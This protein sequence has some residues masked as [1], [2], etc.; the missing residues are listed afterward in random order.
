[1]K[2]KLLNL[3]RAR[4]VVLDLPPVLIGCYRFSAKR[5][6]LTLGQLSR[7]FVV[8]EDLIVDIFMESLGDKFRLI[9]AEVGGSQEAVVPLSHLPYLALAL[10]MLDNPVARR[11]VLMGVATAIVSALDEGVDRPTDEDNIGVLRE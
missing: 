1:M 6:Y 3:D 11:M 2:S 10:H 4:A 7:S 8:G 9:Q 5:S